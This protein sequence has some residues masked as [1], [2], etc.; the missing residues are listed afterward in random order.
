MPRITSL[1]KSICGKIMAIPMRIT[2]KM[3]RQMALLTIG[4][5][6]LSV[7]AF[8]SNGF[9]GS[10]KNAVSANVINSGEGE[11]FEDDMQDETDEILDNAGLDNTTVDEEIA[12]L[13]RIEQRRPEMKRWKDFLRNAG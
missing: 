13:P 9:A 8:S 12:N 10:G 1:L 11:T 6:V 7:V 5:A 4:G 2:K 3:Y